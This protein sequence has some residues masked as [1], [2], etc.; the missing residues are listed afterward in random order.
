VKPP[1]SLPPELVAASARAT[2]H[3]TALDPVALLSQKAN[4]M[5]IENIGSDE[6]ITLYAFESSKT[7]SKCYFCGLVPRNYISKAMAHDS[8]DLMIGHGRP[9]FTQSHASGRTK[10]R[11]DR[12]GTSSVEPL[13]FSRS[14][15]GIKP[16]Q[17]D[18]LEEFRHFHNLYHDRRNDRHI[19]ID[20]RGEEDVV[21]EASEKL[22]RAKLRYIRQF[23][24]ARHLHLAVFFDHRAHVPM[25]IDTAKSKIPDQTVA[26]SHLRFSFNVGNVSGDTFSRLVGKK[27][28]DPLPLKE[29]GIWPYE[30]K[31][32]RQFADY[33]IGTDAKGRP[34]VHSCN[35]ETLANYFGKNP[36]EPHF[37]TPVWFKREVLR[38][39][40]DHPTKYSVEDGYLRCGSLWG[41]QLDNNLPNHVMVYLGDLGAL[42]YEEQLY[43]KSFNIPP[44]SGQSSET[45]YKRSFLAEFADPTSPDLVLKQRLVDLQEGWEQRFGW[46]LFRP[47][48]DDDAHVV[49]Q[50]RVPLTDSIGEFEHQ[51]LLLVKLLIDSLNDKQLVRELGSVEPEEK[52]ISKFDRFL[53]KK[54]Y[55]YRHRDLKLLRS[56]Q[57]LRSSAAA[58]GK[59]KHFDKISRELGLNDKPAFEVFRELLTHVNEMLS[60]L[61]VFFI[62]PDAT[63]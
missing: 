45:N 7:G 11:Y 30:G 41:L 10:T 51:I 33:I 6:W 32:I 20:D 36:D 19:Y 50:L 44:A 49:K 53:E 13:V 25:D 1:R 2:Q 9:G 24:A 56:L 28:I 62:P 57:A 29:C 14:F 61:Q 47:L 34:V 8:W 55:P 54:G 22:V 21:V 39:Y 15:H 4:L 58:H 26:R 60:D 5:E 38:K 35:E 31:S 16:D 27:L 43:W 48:H 46:Q 3:A 12:F 17:F 59:G 18:L 40:Y 37:L 63:N 42:S 52:S 23:M